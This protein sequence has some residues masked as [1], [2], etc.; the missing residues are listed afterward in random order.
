MKQGYDKGSVIFLRKL[1]GLFEATN[2]D[3]VLNFEQDKG[4]TYEHIYIATKYKF[5][6]GT[7]HHSNHIHKIDV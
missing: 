5:P 2:Q 3:G 1:P 7:S 6:T 4:A